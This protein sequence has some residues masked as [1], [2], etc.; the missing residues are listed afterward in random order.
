[1]IPALGAYYRPDRLEDALALLASEPG[2]EVLAGGTDLLLSGLPKQALVD[3]TR[4]GLD[5]LEATPEGL[6]L[7]GTLTVQQ[8]LESSAAASWADGV[9]VG[10]CL[11]F[12][13]LQVRNVATV[14]GNV[15]HALPAADLVPVLLALDAEVELARADDSAGGVRR[16]RLPLD[17]FATGPGRTV[18]QPGELVVALHVPASA[19]TW[20]AQFRKIGRVRKDLAQV[21]CAVALDIAAGRVRGA[22]IA[23]GAVHPT[24]V[25]IRAAEEHL[26]GGRPRAGDWV[27]RVAAAV[28]RVRRTVQPITD[29]RATRE[30]RRHTAGV[31]VARCLEWVANPRTAG[32]VPCLEDGPSYRLGLDAGGG[33]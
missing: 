6:V 22:R 21:N 7:G 32:R 8:L 3:V 4:L 15:A 16:R 27:D 20:R 31:L 29:V 30:W 13:T 19:R 12:G 26:E 17:G 23:L 11:E 9:L 5:R 2:S 25:R 18:L 24:V 28:D 33:A 10:A 14:G 1:M